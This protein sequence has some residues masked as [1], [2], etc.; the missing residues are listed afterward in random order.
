MIPVE[1]PEIV[2]R[3]IDF[4]SGT[5]LFSHSMPSDAKA[6]RAA[7]KKKAA[8]NKKTAV[9]QGETNGAESSP[10]S[11]VNG[12]STP[13]MLS[14]NSSVSECYNHTSFLFLVKPDVPQHRCSLTF[15]T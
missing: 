6:R 8:L 7:N 11:S 14:A 4:A 1:L 10:A 13:K 9:L 12:D 5:L 3:V 15:Q 2:T